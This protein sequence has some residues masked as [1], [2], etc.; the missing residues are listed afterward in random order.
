MFGQPHETAYFDCEW[1]MSW[2]KRA[3]TWRVDGRVALAD[4]LSRAQDATTLR[5]RRTSDSDLAQLLAVWW[6]N[7][8]QDNCLQ[9]G[10]WI[11]KIS[12]NFGLR[13]KTR[14]FCGIFE[15]K[16]MP[17][18]LNC[19]IQRSWSKKSLQSLAAR[20]AAFCIFMVWLYL[21]FQPTNSAAK[22]VF[23][24]EVGTAQP[25]SFCKYRTHAQPGDLDPT[26]LLTPLAE[27]TP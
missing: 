19:W 3:E 4:C 20:F 1:S 8:C 25:H 26:L 17:R 24:S 15:M 2:V 23:E 27:V 16:W 10:F 6:F 22:H 12:P 14:P 5:L 13:H 9:D 7:D 21:F 11:P 18:P